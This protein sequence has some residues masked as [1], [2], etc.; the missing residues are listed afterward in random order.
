MK[1]QCTYSG[2]KAVIPY[3][4][5]RCEKHEYK[6]NNKKELVIR[7]AFYNTTAWK[8]LSQRLRQQNPVCQKCHKDI[9]YLVDHILEISVS[10]EN[11]LN[12]NNLMC[13]CRSCHST[14]TGVFKRMM[15]E[16]Q[17]IYQWC[18]N[19]NPN[20]DLTYLHEWIKNVQRDMQ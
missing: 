9:S 14:K 2:C 7:H 11:A 17:K 3:R 18:L 8:K 1:R 13:L 20:P 4:Q 16:P 6:S 12:E 10:E 19:N 15:A 5:R